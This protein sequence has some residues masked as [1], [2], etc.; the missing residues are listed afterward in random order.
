MNSASLSCFRIGLIA[1]QCYRWLKTSSPLKSIVWIAKMATVA[2]KSCAR[3]TASG[4]K[5][6]D[7]NR[8]MTIF[9][10]VTVALFIIILLFSVKL[11]ST[12]FKHSTWCTEYNKTNNGDKINNNSEFLLL[13]LGKLRNSAILFCSCL[14]VL[15]L[16]PRMNSDLFQGQ[17]IF[18][19]ELEDLS[20]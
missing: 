9:H 2:K 15:L 18:G 17:A 3:S 13:L 8:L 6:S 12:K 20:H 4:T 16:H 14:V 11:I 5:R 1:L 10:C 7:N 19:A